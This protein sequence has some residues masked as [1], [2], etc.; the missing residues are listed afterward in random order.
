ML[1][2][3]GT[4]AIVSIGVPLA[5]TYYHNSPDFLPNP[6]PNLLNGNNKSGTVAFLAAFLVTVMVNFAFVG[7][8]PFKKRFYYNPFLVGQLLFGFILV[9]FMYGY[10]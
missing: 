5:I 9:T 3:W 10:T 1:L 7:S 4:A 8:T 2:W 6:T